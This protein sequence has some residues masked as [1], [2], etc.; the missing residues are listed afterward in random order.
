M[1]RWARRAHVYRVPYCVPQWSAGTLAAMIGCVVSGRIARG[2]APA[3][4]A[5]RLAA[6]LGVPGALPSGDGRSAIELALRALEVRPGDDVI[7]PSF[8]CTTIVPPIVAVGAR[9]VLADVGPELNLTAATV[10][11]AL[12]PR[13]RAVIVPHL[14][15]N[16]ADIEPIAALCV[17]RDVSLIDD[18][19]Q[20]MGATVDGRA[21]GT[22]GDAGILSFGRG[23]VCFGTGGGALLSRRPEIIERAA[24]VDLAPARAGD[25]LA[26]ALAVLVWRR[27]RRWSLP[28]QT[29][30]ARLGRRRGT[31]TPYRRRAMAS[32]DAAV[33]S[34]L[35]DR[36]A[37]DLRA[38]RERAGAYAEALAGA[39]G[40]TLVPHRPGSACLSQVVLVDPATNGGGAA[41]LLE[42]LRDAGYEVEASYTPLHVRGEHSVRGAGSLARTEAMWRSL[43]ELPC[44]PSVS[45]T[46][47]EHIAAIAAET[48]RG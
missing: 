29:A 5:R 22:F 24:Q 13:T 43:V 32:L 21:A 19:A 45:L 14:F 9:P 28:L 36:L 31:A 44:E 34:T 6:E 17:A 48:A 11:A 20:A 1:A 47:V 39:R 3:R 42:T 35:L 37:A 18:A 33:A 23:K 25:T 30:L 41:R 4:L 27:W 38:R 46:D 40:L 16:P 8:C 2:P 15:G 7:V 12:T 10:E 26:H